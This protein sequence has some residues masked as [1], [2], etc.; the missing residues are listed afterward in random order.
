MA[1]VRT[2]EG[3]PLHP[4]FFRSG[5]AAFGFWAACLAYCVRYLTDGFIP[6]RDLPLIFPGTPPEDVM[7]LVEI[8]VREGLLEVRGERYKMHDFEHYQPLKKDYLRAQRERITRARQGGIN[9]GISRK[10]AASTKREVF[11]SDKTN[12]EPNRTEPIR[13]EPKVVQ[14]SIVGLTPDATP[15]NGFRHEAETI[16]DFLNEKAGRTFRPSRSNLALIEARLKAGASV[17]DC[18]GVIVRKVRAWATDPKMA[19]YLRPATLFGA[20]KFDQYIGEQG[21]PS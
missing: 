7:T 4:K 15:L 12:S 14:K 3:A 8:L 5:V 19:P 20:V 9:S 2:E 16:L 13:T 1:W 18:R 6:A 10:R 11:P 17:E 21:R